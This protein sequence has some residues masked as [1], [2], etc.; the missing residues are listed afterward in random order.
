MPYSVFDLYFLIQSAEKCDE[1][2]FTV[3]GQSCKERFPAQ[4]S[5][6]KFSE[7]P[8]YTQAKPF[9]FEDGCDKD[10]KKGKIQCVRL[11]YERDPGSEQAC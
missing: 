5:G 7:L 9:F 10:S 3:I 2:I 1:K 4:L 8:G 6:K 11:R